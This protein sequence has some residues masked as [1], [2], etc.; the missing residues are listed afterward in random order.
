MLTLFKNQASYALRSFETFHLNLSL[1]LTIIISK[2]ITIS[3]NFRLRLTVI[4]LLH[5]HINTCL[6][7]T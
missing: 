4:F 2:F 5:V 1:S 6:E 7:T 3:N